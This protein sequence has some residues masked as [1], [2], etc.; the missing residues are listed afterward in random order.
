MTQSQVS[1]CASVPT[2]CLNVLHLTSSPLPGGCVEQKSLSHV[3][4]CRSSSYFKVS[5]DRSDSFAAAHP[6]E[7][8]AHCCLHTRMIVPRTP[9]LR[10]EHAYLQLGEHLLDSSHSQH[11]QQQPRRIPAHPFSSSK[12]GSIKHVMRLDVTAMTDVANAL[13]G[14][15]FEIAPF[16]SV[17]KDACARAQTES[18]TS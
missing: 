6:L 7:R 12:A 11:T 16:K 10:I 18:S 9:H 8:P 13:P 15:I 4:T 17:I 3:A 5:V 14:Q 2:Q 1:G